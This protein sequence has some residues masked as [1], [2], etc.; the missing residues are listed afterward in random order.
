MRR[1][2]GAPR[3]VARASHARLTSAVATASAR[4]AHRTA[5]PVAER[6]T[7]PTRTPTGSETRSTA[8]VSRY[9]ASPPRT[10]PGSASPS[11]ESSRRSGAVASVMASWP[12]RVAPRSGHV[13]SK[14]SAGQKWST[15]PSSPDSVDAEPRS[16]LRNHYGDLAARPPLLLS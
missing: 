8:S 5:E 13:T 12:R 6:R 11:P 15:P 16:A 4:S 10:R 2:R 1:D 3:Y 14:A 9:V 7:R